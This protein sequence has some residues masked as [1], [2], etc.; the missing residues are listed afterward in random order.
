MRDVFDQRQ[1]RYGAKLCGQLCEGAFGS[2]TKFPL[3]RGIAAIQT[4]LRLGE[5]IFIE[6]LFPNSPTLQKIDGDIRGDSSGPGGEM[7]PRIETSVR[8]MNAPEGLDGEIL[9]RGR[10]ANDAHDPAV[11][12]SLE[13]PEQHLESL[14]VA[15]REFFQHFRRLFQ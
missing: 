10:I 7:P 15:G 9:G 4:P 12:L 1:R 5:P 8:P 14:K 13:L 2:F 6:R 3:D 11:N